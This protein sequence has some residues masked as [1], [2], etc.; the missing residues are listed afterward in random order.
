M[1]LLSS[2]KGLSN[3]EQTFVSGVSGFIVCYFT[4]V[5]SILASHAPSGT[6]PFDAAVALGFLAAFAPSTYT[7]LSG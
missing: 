6:S 3:G 7:H 2:L 5:A 4:G 1:G